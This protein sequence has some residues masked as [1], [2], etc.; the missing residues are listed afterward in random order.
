MKSSFVEKQQQSSFAAAPTHQNGMPAKARESV[1][2][3]EERPSRI[4]QPN[5]YLE[6]FGKQRIKEPE[7]PAT[8]F[9]ESFYNEDYHE[10][11]SASDSEAGTFIDDYESDFED[12]NIEASIATLQKGL[13][14]LGNCVRKFK[15]QTDLSATKQRQR[16]LPKQA[17]R[18]VTGPRHCPNCRGEGDSV[19][20][21][22]SGDVFAKLEGIKRECYEKIEAQM[23]VLISC[24]KLANDI[25]KNHLNLKY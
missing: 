25:Y 12:D 20:P 17:A 5:E 7:I 6:K 22:R 23:K 16:E 8:D 1:K 14:N 10:S 13:R 24:D 2:F 19:Q 3:N 18:N 11:F 4:M 9:V 21:K 15:S